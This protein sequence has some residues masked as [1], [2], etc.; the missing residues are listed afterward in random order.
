[1][2]PINSVSGDGRQLNLRIRLRF[3]KPLRGFFRSAVWATS[4]EMDGMAALFLFGRRI[5]EKLGQK[6][7]KFLSCR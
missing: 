1:M 4:I 3:R 5:I 7:S 6:T 2:K